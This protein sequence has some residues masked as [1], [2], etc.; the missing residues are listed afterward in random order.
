MRDVDLAE[1]LQ[2]SFAGLNLCAQICLNAKFQQSLS[3]GFS[4]HSEFCTC[5]DASIQSGFK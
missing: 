5:K 3:A 1:R 4:D 2:Q